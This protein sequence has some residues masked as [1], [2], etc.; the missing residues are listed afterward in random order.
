MIQENAKMLQ[1]S[2]FNMAKPEIKHVIDKHP[3]RQTKKL[4]S[5]CFCLKC[6]A[7][8]FMLWLDFGRCKKCTECDMV[9]VLENNVYWVTK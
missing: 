2:L 9:Y 6:K 7:M 5:H 4:Y 3:K 1:L 8:A